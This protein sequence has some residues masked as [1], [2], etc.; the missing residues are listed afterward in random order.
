MECQELLNFGAVPG[1][2]AVQSGG[3][4]AD[5]CCKHV[6]GIE[7]YHSKL[8]SNLRSNF[9]Q[10]EKDLGV[11]LIGDTKE[12]V[13]VPTAL[14]IKVWP[15]LNEML[16]VLSG[17]FGCVCDEL[18]II[19]PGTSK[20]TIDQFL[21][22]VYSG[23]CNIKEH[24]E[25]HQVKELLAKFGLNWDLSLICEESDL[26][27]IFEQSGVD[28]V[29]ENS[30]D[31]FKL[32]RVRIVDKLGQLA[33]VQ[34]RQ[35]REEGA[36]QDECNSEQ[37]VEGDRS[38]DLFSPSEEN[39]LLASEVRSDSLVKSRGELMDSSASLGHG[40]VY[41]SLEAGNVGLDQKKGNGPSLAKQP[42]VAKKNEIGQ[43]GMLN[44]DSFSEKQDMVYKQA[45]P[46][47]T[48]MDEEEK[49]RYNVVNSGGEG[50]I[51]EHSA[52]DD[53]DDTFQDCFESSVFEEN[54][55]RSPIKFKVQDFEEKSL[56]SKFCGGGFVLNVDCRFGL[57]YV[58]RL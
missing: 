32:S 56:C 54:F 36:L 38:W 11:S 23:H 50:G 43:R 41:A 37:G 39:L 55:G 1:V 49:Q 31:T 53:A 12:R 28:C 16:P 26:T 5:S 21:D 2:I 52:D 33:E 42:L 13:G 27:D 22:L 10:Q 19:L 14:F 3:Y 45:V 25:V 48:G 18:V 20:K 17:T 15:R 34:E 4:S 47:W 40:S 30:S 51:Q 6:G 46:Q 8:L 44:R 29:K 9:H 35:Y 57:N 7:L 58:C 24:S